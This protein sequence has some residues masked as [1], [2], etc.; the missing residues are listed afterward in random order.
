M[1]H[2]GFRAG[3][4]ALVDV[5]MRKILSDSSEIALLMTATKQIGESIRK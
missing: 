4:I 3:D 1:A 5:E 2:D